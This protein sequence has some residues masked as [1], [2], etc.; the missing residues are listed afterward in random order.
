MF[1]L[2][3][4]Q[5]MSQRQPMDRML[6]GPMYLILPP[7]LWHTLKTFL[8]RQNATLLDRAETALHTVGNPRSQGWASTS[9][10]LKNKL[11][12]RPHVGRYLKMKGGPGNA[13]HGTKRNRIH[14]AHGGT[15]NAICPWFCSGRWWLL[16]PTKWHLVVGKWM[17]ASLK[18]VLR[19]NVTR[20]NRQN[21]P[22]AYYVHT[23]KMEWGRKRNNT[24]RKESLTEKQINNW[25]V[26][27]SINMFLESERK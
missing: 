16:K 8:G 6:N 25:Y 19:S 22:R 20:F 12:D 15:F 18:M 11:W 23:M 17:A 5:P 26:F 24:E 10:L 2:H 1:W 3:E 7:N 13:H 14:H 4:Q 21:K 27:L 9:R